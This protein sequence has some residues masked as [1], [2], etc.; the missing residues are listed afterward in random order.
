[1]LRALAPPAA[2]AYQPL[3]RDPSDA[4][5]KFKGTLVHEAQLSCFYTAPGGKKADVACRVGGTKPP[6]VPT[7]RPS[8]CALGAGLPGHSWERGLTRHRAGPRQELEILGRTKAGGVAAGRR[9][10]WPWCS[11]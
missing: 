9:S 8:P 7:P 4:D 6:R 2:P 11:C 1:M 10:V 3:P 5:G